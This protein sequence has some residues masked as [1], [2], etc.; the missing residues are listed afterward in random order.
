MWKGKTN[1]FV[2]IL[3]LFCFKYDHDLFLLYY[4]VICQKYLWIVEI[5]CAYFEVISKGGCY[6]LLIGNLVFISGSKVSF[7]LQWNEPKDDN[8]TKVEQLLLPDLKTRVHFTVIWWALYVLFKRKN[9]DFQLAF[10][11]NSFTGNLRA[12]AVKNVR[13]TSSS[14]CH[15][16]THNWMCRNWYSL[17]SNEINTFWSGSPTVD[18]D[19][20]YHLSLQLRLRLPGWNRNLSAIYATQK[21]GFAPL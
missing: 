12:S 21:G 2:N 5:P 16:S 10:F 19:G 4:F 13:F 8:S 3:K 15:S 20:L 1:A 7:L 9:N 6:L 17:A 18:D 14:S 11:K